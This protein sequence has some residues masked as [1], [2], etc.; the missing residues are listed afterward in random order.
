MATRVMPRIARITK[1]MGIK[2]TNRRRAATILRARAVA[3][4]FGG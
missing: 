4:K 2:A 1:R 3:Q